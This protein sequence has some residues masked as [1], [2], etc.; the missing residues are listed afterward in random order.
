MS[1]ILKSTSV[2]LSSIEE[3]MGT[4]QESNSLGPPP[5]QPPPRPPPLLAIHSAPLLA[6]LA[7]ATTSTGRQRRYAL[8]PTV[9]TKPSSK[10][11]VRNRTISSV[12]Q[13]PP[14]RK[15]TFAN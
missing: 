5:P 12:Y 9:F 3:W 1:P 14:R 11:R 13:L 6:A 10:E 2:T 8:D 15:S 7:L 4:W